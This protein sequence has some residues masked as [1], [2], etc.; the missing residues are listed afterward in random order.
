MPF[1]V[2]DRLAEPLYCLIPVFNPWRFKSRWKHVER[3]IK[4]ISDAGATIVLIEAGFNRRELAFA[5]SGL[6]GLPATCGVLGS[7]PKFRHKYIGLHTKDELWAKENLLNIGAQ[8]LPYDWQQLCTVDGDVEFSRPNFIG[9]TIHKLQHYSVVQ[10]FSQARDLGPN[11]EMLPEDYPHAD[12]LGFVHAW[13]SGALEEVKHRHHRHHHG[14]HHH[15][16]HH[17]P[18]PYDDDAKSYSSLQQPRVWPGLA[19]AYTRKAWDDLGGLIDFAIWGGADFHMS[20][21]LA[22]RPEKMM[23]D[24]LHSNYRQMCMEW[25]HRCQ[26]HIRKNVGVVE[27]AVFHQWHGRKSARGY[28]SKH[29]LLAQIGFDPLHHLKRDAAGIFQLH[30]DGSDAYVKLRDTL[31]TIAVERDEDSNDTRLDLWDQG[32]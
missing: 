23:R 12:G 16:H 5:D 29:A 15:H 20:W 7:D 6:D 13:Q 25:F 11:Y 1:H 31:R 21:A 22:E 32:H 18:P 26:R 10:M 28:S 3:A 17:D 4:H 24:D 2:H 9:E 30:D 8:N 27:G 14:R 19:W